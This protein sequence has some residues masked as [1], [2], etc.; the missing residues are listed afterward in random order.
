MEHETLDEVFTSNGIVLDTKKLREEHDTEL[1]NIAKYRRLADYLTAAQLY[2]KDN[3]F[4]EQ[5][6][7]KQHIKERLLGHWGTCPGI[8]F[9][10]SHL[11]YLIKKQ[12]LNMFCVVGPGHGAAAVYANLLVEG[13]LEACNG[14]Y[15]A[16]SQG[17]ENLIKSFCWPGG[18]PRYSQPKID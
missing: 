9:M 1:K 15:S 5:P 14:D 12:N 10:W 6:L 7:K 11:S 3:V 4:V 17:M 2:L 18:F 8:T 13:A 16:D